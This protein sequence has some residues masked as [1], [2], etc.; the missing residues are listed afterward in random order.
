MHSASNLLQAHQKHA[1]LLK[2]FCKFALMLTY[3]YQR[4]NKL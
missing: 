4:I 3:F 2:I 1:F